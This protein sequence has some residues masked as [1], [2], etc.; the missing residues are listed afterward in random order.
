MLRLGIGN[1]ACCEHVLGRE[2]HL[3][4]LVLGLFGGYHDGS[5]LSS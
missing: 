2:L 3:H 4:A 5:V 1:E